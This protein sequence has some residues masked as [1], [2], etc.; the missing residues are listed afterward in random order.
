MNCT[1]ILALCVCCSISGAGDEVV[2]LGEEGSGFTVQ[3]GL[4]A[5]SI[6]VRL[7]VWPKTCGLTEWQW[8]PRLDSYLRASQMDASA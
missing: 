2:Q 5:G 6:F 7:Q 3:F 4:G 8:S 1:N